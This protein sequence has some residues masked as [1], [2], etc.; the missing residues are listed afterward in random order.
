MSN[1]KK[2]MLYLEAETLV[3]LDKL[4]KKTG[5]TRSAIIRSFMRDGLDNVKVVGH[6]TMNPFD[7]EEED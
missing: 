3:D 7:D 6:F 4:T 5:L 1:L 2:L